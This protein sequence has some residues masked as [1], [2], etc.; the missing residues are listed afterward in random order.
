MTT[1]YLNNLEPPREYRKSQPL[2]TTLTM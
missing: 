1:N 2:Q